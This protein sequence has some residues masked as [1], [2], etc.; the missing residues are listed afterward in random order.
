MGYTT[1]HE[2]SKQIGVPVFYRC[3]QCGQP[4]LYY[5]QVKGAKKYKSTTT[6][7]G[8]NEETQRKVAEIQLDAKVKEQLRC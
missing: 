2:I 6:R 5:H 7:A 1:D 3:S 4:V 8:S